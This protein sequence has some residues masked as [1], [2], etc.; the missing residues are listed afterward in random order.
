ML[1]IY[2]VYIYALGGKRNKNCF[3]KGRH[4]EKKDRLGKRFMKD[5]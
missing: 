5:L 1:H 2:S 3:S 4:A